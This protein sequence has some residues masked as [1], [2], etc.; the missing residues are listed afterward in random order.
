MI[1]WLS[2]LLIGKKVFLGISFTLLIALAVLGWQYREQVAQAAT[3]RGNLAQYQRALINQQQAAARLRQERDQL[4]RVL[5]DREK[6]KQEV[7]AQAHA[8][9][10][11][12]DR[13]RREHDDV[14]K[15]A[16]Q[17]VPDAVIERLRQRPAGSH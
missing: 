15:W 10:S 17:R 9:R 12:I 4:E 1:T 8:L 2:K 14:E 5:A 16:T 7:Q 11:D 6:A 3:L 13:L